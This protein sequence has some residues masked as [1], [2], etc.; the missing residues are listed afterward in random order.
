MWFA[1]DVM[2][3]IQYLFINQILFGTYYKAYIFQKRF[4]LGS[5]HPKGILNPR[6]PM[7]QMVETIE[8]VEQCQTWGRIL[9]WMPMKFYFYL[10]AKRYLKHCCI[11][12]DPTQ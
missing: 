8:W 12:D 11:M 5:D 10:V 7:T 4:R 6:I 9:V 2:L 1:V 3:L